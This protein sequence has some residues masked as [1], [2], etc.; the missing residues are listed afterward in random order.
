[1]LLAKLSTQ[2]ATLSL[3]KSMLV[4]HRLALMLRQRHQQL[5]LLLKVKWPKQLLKLLQRQQLWPLVV[6]LMHQLFRQQL[7]QQWKAQ[8]HDELSYLTSRYSFKRWTSDVRNSP[9]ASSRNS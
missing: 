9:L 5:V 3:L 6:P 8:A 4:S 2:N 7:Q 1:M